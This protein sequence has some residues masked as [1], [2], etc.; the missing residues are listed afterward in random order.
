[1]VLD[2]YHYVFYIVSLRLHHSWTLTNTCLYFIYLL[3]SFVRAEKQKCCFVSPLLPPDIWRHSVFPTC[4]AFNGIH[5]HET[6]R[7]LVMTVFVGFVVIIAIISLAFSQ[8]SFFHTLCMSFPLCAKQEILFVF[9][10]LW[11]ADVWAEMFLRCEGDMEEVEAC[12]AHC[13]G[14]LI[15]Q[16]DHRDGGWT[17]VSGRGLKNVT[18]IF[19][20]R[21][22]GSVWRI[23]MQRSTNLG[24]NENSM[25]DF[26][27]QILPVCV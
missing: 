7:S 25:G 19:M 23:I 14:W 18:S 24:V 3:L 15:N 13:T 2:W 10:L 6:L 27:H 5:F 26:A 17:D 12:S 21:I 16:V 1:M 9:P 22:S 8:L 4:L 20:S 11:T